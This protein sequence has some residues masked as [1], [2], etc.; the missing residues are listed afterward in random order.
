M[1]SSSPGSSTSSIHNSVSSSSSSSYSS[2]SQPTQQLAASVSHA[3]TNASKMF[4][5]PPFFKYTGCTTN[6]ISGSD[7]TY[8]YTMPGK[9]VTGTG[10]SNSYL[11]NNSKRVGF[12]STSFTRSVTDHCRSCDSKVI[13][14]TANRCTYLFKNADS[15]KKLPNDVGNYGY[16][17]HRCQECNK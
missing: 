3:N 11:E 17:R 12:V 9:T 7:G 15:K 4:N 8:K 5:K 2:S 1:S 14:E 13:H 10:Y 16:S 6:K